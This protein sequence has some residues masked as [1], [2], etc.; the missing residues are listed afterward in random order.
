M[1]IAGILFDKDGTLIDFE[2][3]WH[4]VNRL[5]ALHV[6]GGDQ[7]R[8]ENLLER[9]GFDHAAQ[10]CRPGTILAAGTA[11]ELAAVWRPDL[12]GAALA[13]MVVELDDIFTAGALEHLT[14]LTDLD[15]LFGAL[16]SGGHRLGIATNDVTRSAIGL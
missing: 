2:A 5:A 4:P 7:A 16:K 3:T 11:E 13:A 10:R 15:A 9:A 1:S 14:T 8:A 12:S 6:A